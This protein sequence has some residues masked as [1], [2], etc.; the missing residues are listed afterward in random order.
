VNY[1]LMAHRAIPHSVTR[2]IPFYLLHG[3]QMRL[4]MKDDLTTAKF[5]SRESKDGRDSIQSHIDTLSERFEE[6]YH[7]TRENN[8]VGRER[9]KEQYDKGTKLTTF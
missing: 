6:S 1:A 7:V 4:P 9:Q 2:Y 8:K 3:R 5:L